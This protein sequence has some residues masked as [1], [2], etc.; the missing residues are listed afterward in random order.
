MEH[1]NYKYVKCMYLYL[2]TFSSVSS[3]YLN[4]SS[5]NKQLPF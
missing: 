1:I 2:H 5:D 4:Y 3:E